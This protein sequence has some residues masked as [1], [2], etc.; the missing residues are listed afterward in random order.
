MFE[1][2]TGGYVLAGYHE[3]VY[4]DRTEAAAAKAKEQNKILWRISS[5][6]FG[7]IRHDV[8]LYPLEEFEDRFA[9]SKEETLAK[10]P[11]ISAAESVQEELKKI[12]LWR[13]NEPEAPL[14]DG[15]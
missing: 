5:T 6:L 4:N 11:P 8:I 3:V 10:Y 14:S 15:Y 12:N 1:Y 9:E 7:H 2:I 13:A